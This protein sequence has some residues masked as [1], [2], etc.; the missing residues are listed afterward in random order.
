M[1]N[2]FQRALDIILTEVR[3]NTCLVY[4]EDVLIFCKSLEEKVAHVGDVSNI[5]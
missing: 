3:W 2:F 4:L 5:S 1:P